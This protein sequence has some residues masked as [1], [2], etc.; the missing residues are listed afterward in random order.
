MQTQCH[1]EPPPGSGHR[2]P[3]RH[4]PLPAQALSLLPSDD[5]SPGRILRSKPTPVSF[6]RLCDNQETEMGEDGD[7]R[8]MNKLA[9]PVKMLASYLAIHPSSPRAHQIYAD[10]I[11]RACR[12]QRF[13]L[14]GGTMRPEAKKRKQ[15]IR[16]TSSTQLIALV[17]KKAHPNS[18][19]APGPKKDRDIR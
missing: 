14:G 19:P 11:Y 6:L 2:Q 18:S 16:D 17:Q 13:S 5:I 7:N 12:L 1:V 10:A 9:V 15:T 8:C 4:A 3:R